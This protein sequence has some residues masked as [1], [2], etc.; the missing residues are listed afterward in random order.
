M[1]RHPPVG[2]L[3]PAD[4][5]LVLGG[6]KIPHPFH[7]PALQFLFVGQSL[8]SHTGLTVAALLPLCLNSL[9]PSQVDISTGEQI[10]HLTEHILDELESGFLAGT[11]DMRGDPGAATH[12]ERPPVIV[13]SIRA[14]ELRVGRQHLDGMP[15]HFD[16]RDDHN[17]QAVGIMN[18]VTDLLLGVIT[19]VFHAVTGAP[20]SNTLELGF[21]FDLD[22]PS[23]V[24]G[25]MPVKTVQL[26]HCHD[27]KIFFDKIHTEE[28]AGNVQVHTPPGITGMI[29]DLNIWHI[30]YHPGDLAGRLYG[31]R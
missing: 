11:E 12:A 13:L 6:Q 1:G 19:S 7:E 8:L 10:D 5:L 3:A 9:I 20:G 14:G 2:D 21:A 31:C 29:C 27:V 28:M 25:K 24:I 15:R 23:L 16:L 17:M 30:P 22:T 4:P 26:V 18:D